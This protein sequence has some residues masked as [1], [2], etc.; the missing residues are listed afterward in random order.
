MKFHVGSRKG[1]FTFEKLAAGWEIT[2]VD[3]LGDNVSMLLHDRR[4]ETL[5]A[6]LNL[7][8]FGAKLRRSSDAGQN[9]DELTPP[10]FPEG[11][12]V[13]IPQFDGSEAKQKP[14]SLS[15]IWSL[16]TG[17]N[18][19]PGL[20][21]AGTIPAGLFVSRDRGDTWELN[22]SLWNLPERQQWF[23]GGK[24]D[25][26][27]HSISVDPRDS[28]HVTIAISCGG[29]W[30]TTDLG[31]TWSCRSDGMR[32]EYMPPDRQFDPVIQDPHR[33]MRCPGAPDNFWVQ[34]HNGIFKST[35][36]CEKWEELTAEPSSFG[37]GVAV[38][39]NDPKTAWFVPGIKDECRVPVDG[40]LVVTRTTNGGESFESLSAGLPQAHSYDIAY[41]H[42][43]EVDES[44]EVLI[45]GT[46]TGNLFVSENGGEAWECL[47][48]TLPPIYV[49]R[50]A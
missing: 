33:L 27:L 34:H 48:T 30:Q 32:A 4:D 49:A 37:L 21:W 3:F 15:E 23:G 12:T 29:V 28:R 20:L 5:Y 41:R 42:A 13:P 14:A 47:S 39:P 7:G 10:T 18:D 25:A 6:G 44:G 35:N 45:F 43:L 40:K 19:Q 50:F 9:W 36:N 38:H 26:G 22:D 16:E 46:T 24:D 8:H 17:G 1:L 31:V 2:R 11:E